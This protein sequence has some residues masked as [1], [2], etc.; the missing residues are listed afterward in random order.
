MTR[1]IL[2]IKDDRRAALL[3][4]ILRFLNLPIVREEKEKQ[5]PDPE[6]FYS[7]FKLDLSNFRFDRQEANIR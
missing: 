3:R 4:A 5:G 1:I 2:E 6:S 7:L